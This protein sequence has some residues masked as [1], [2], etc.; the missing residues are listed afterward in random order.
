MNVDEAREEW[1]RKV[2]GE[3]GCCPVCDRWGQIYSLPINRTKARSLL[4][5]CSATINED[6]WVDVPNTAPRFVIRSNQLPSLHYW[7][8]VES[9]GFRTGKWRPTALGLDFAY[10]LVQVPQRVFVYN[11]IV[12][13][14]G[15]KQVYI[16]DCFKEQFEYKE[17]MADIYSRRTA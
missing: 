17:M 3:G 13:R 9:P 7:N 2:A 10:G 16:Q 4:W 1:Q 15:D 6:G 5:L 14:F 8:L 11:D 12:Q